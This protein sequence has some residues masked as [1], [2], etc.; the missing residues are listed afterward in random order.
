MWT[1]S[2]ILF[3]DSSAIQNSFAFFDV[4]GFEIPMTLLF[5]NYFPWFNVFVD[6]EAAVRR[7]S[8]NTCSQEFRNIHRKA[9]VW[10]P[11]FNRPATLLK[12]DSL[13]KVFSCEYCKISKNSFLKNFSSGCFY[14]L[15]FDLVQKRVLDLHSL[16]NIPVGVS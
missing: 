3:I 2:P 14:W 1:T 10:V 7:C 4:P 16:Q 9:P 5:L 8:W 12:R 13:T 11:L 6:V 15:H